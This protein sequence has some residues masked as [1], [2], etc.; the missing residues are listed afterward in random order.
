MAL[1]F[2]PASSRNGCS[3]AGRCPL[4]KRSQAAE[5]IPVAHVS[6][7]AG[8]REHTDRCSPAR[9]G[10]RPRIAC[11]P[12]GLTVTTRKIAVSV[13]GLSTDCGTGGAD[14][15]LVKMRAPLQSGRK[16]SFLMPA[17]YFVAGRFGLSIGRT[18]PENYLV[19]YVAT[20]RM[21]QLTKSCRP[22]PGH[23]TVPAP[24]PAAQDAGAR[25][26]DDAR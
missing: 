18:V 1:Y 17:S 4:N 14:C 19:T 8:I 22:A 21:C 11:S 10:S 3:P 24:R 12:P 26:R 15:G 6:A 13:G 5:P 25:F 20:R 7:A 9:S 23:L 16:V 2:A